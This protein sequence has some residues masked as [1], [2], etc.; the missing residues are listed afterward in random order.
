MTGALVLVVGLAG[1]SANK[2]CESGACVGDTN[3]TAAVEARFDQYPELQPPDD[4]DV[5]TVNHIVYLYGLV[6]TALD[7]SMAETVARKTPGVAKV[8]N[9]I[10]LNNP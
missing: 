10:A 6:D 4:I 5:Q 7:S 3:I 8:V 1:C 9:L 2:T